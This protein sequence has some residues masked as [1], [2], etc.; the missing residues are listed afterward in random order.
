M[1]QTLTGAPQADRDCPG[2]IAFA[3]KTKRFEPTR[4]AKDKEV[5]R[6]S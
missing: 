2:S 5:T 4:T 6:K 1:R 3:L